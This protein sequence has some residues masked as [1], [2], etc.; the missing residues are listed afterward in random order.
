M[1]LKKISLY[2]ARLKLKVPFT[3]SFGTQDNIDRLFIALTDEKGNTGWAEIPTLNEPAYKAESDFPAVVTSLTNFVIP[4]LKT[5]QKTK[6]NIDSLD[7]LQASYQWIKGANFAKYGVE[8]AFWHLLSL[9]KKQPLYRLFGGSKKTIVSGV[10]IGGQNLT[11]VLTRA[12]MAVG[13]GFK[14]IKVKI[15]PGFDLEPIKA[16]RKKYP[17]LLI[18]VD[19]NSAYNL[20]NWKALQKLDQY[21]L[22]LIEQPLSDADLLDHSQISTKLKTPICLDESIHSLDDA[23]YAIKLW[24]DNKNLKRLI[25]NI[26]PP[27]VGGFANSIAIAKLANKHKVKTWVGGMLDSGWG[28]YMNLCF[29]SRPELSLPGDHFSPT[30]EYFKTDVLNQP[31]THTNGSYDFSQDVRIDS[32]KIKKLSKNLLNIQL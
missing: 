17:S 16:L 2:H 26:K 4:S 27:R 9:R 3:T 5:Y 19:G 13:M 18:Q 22:L 30:G 11:D 15:W 7:K 23:R 14:R 1:K 12:E 21:N 29:N 20:T 31:L 32:A 8:A 25:I 24:Q 6:G 10:S 28:K